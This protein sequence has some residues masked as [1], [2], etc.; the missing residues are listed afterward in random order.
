MSDWCSDQTK[1]VQKTGENPHAELATWGTT[2]ARLCQLQPRELP[3]QANGWLGC[4][5]VDPFYVEPYEDVV[6]R[7]A[8]SIQK[9]LARF[10][11]DYAWIS[12]GNLSD[13]QLGNWLNWNK[14]YFPNGHEYLH[15]ELEKSG[16]K[17][18]LWC[19]A[20]TLSS[21]LEDKVKELWD[22]LVKQPDGKEP[23]VC[24]PNWGYGLDG[25]RRTIRSQYMLS[26]PAILR[27][28]STWQKYS[29]PT[30]AGV[31]AIT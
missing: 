29:R 7:N 5:W 23:M 22:A 19:A 20:F 26:I 11:L 16:L 17:W 14:R 25:P 15:S 2:A 10:G 1:S 9:R 4:S 28:C 3:A 30:A 6:L 21:K 8:K 12:L 27:L 31:F 18:G 13:C 24:S